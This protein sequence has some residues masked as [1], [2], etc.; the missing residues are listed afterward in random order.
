[1]DAGRWGGTSPAASAAS[2]GGRGRPCCLEKAC[3]DHHPGKFSPWARKAAGLCNTLSSLRL[4][5]PP[6]TAP[7]TGHP[8]KSTGAGELSL[9]Q[10]QIGLFWPSFLPVPQGKR[11]LSALTEELEAPSGEARSGCEHL[12]C[13]GRGAVP[14]QS[15]WRTGCTSQ[16]TAPAE[17]L[18]QQ[19]RGEGA[20]I[21]PG[22]SLKNQEVLNAAPAA[23]HACVGS[24][25]RG[26]KNIIP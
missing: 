2:P 16:G 12:A 18:E 6:A 19:G 21:C 10:R 24:A 5:P 25:D 13:H 26:H 8:S 17:E 14:A 3:P 22:E 7:V 20:F 11:G 9:W 15:G 23:H 4:P 1:M